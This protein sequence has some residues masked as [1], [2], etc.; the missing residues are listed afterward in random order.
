ME[1]DRKVL[2]A[3]YND[4][5]GITRDFNL[6]ILKRINRELN[7][8]FDI[9]KFRHTA[10]F[11]EKHSRIEMHL[12]SKEEQKIR[13]ESLDRTI[14]FRKGETIHTENSYKFSECMIQNFA[15]QAGLK[16]VKTWNDPKRYFSLTLFQ[17]L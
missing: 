7:A 8:A 9:D 15:A 10:F 12:V 17:S 16:I 6:N 14:H 13:I 2:H 11:N 3:A 5:Q 1:K 4:G